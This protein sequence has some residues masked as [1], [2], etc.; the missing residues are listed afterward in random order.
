VISTAPLGHGL[1]GGAWTKDT[2]FAPGDWRGERYAPDLLG[3]HLARVALL[4]PLAT[5]ET[6]SLAELA[7]RFALGPPEVS[8]VAPSVRTRA[9]VDDLIRA[10]DGR[11]LGDSLLQRIAEALS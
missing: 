1:L 8:C 2:V 11:R 7:L 4:A 5:R 6:D 9:H 3:P 10:A